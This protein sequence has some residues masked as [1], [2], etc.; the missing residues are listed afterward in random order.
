M[1]LLESETQV[2]ASLQGSPSCPPLPRPEAHGLPPCNLVSNSGCI[3]GSHLGRLPLGMFSASAWTQRRCLRQDSQESCSFR[4]RSTRCAGSHPHPPMQLWTDGA[5]LL[6]ELSEGQFHRPSLH[7]PTPS[8]WGE[9][10]SGPCKS[11]IFGVLIIWASVF[12]SVWKGLNFVMW[13]VWS[14]PPSTRI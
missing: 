7:S 12:P 11:P 14:N 1:G 3:E 6:S 2:A 4:K 9:G 13:S 8:L 10:P 5:V